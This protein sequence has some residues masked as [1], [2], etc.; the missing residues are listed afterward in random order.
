MQANVTPL[1]QYGP[2]GEQWW[3][4]PAGATLYAS[5]GVPVGTA[6]AIGT[7]YLHAGSSMMADGDV[8]LPLQTIGGYDAAANVV[9]LTVTADAVRT[10]FGGA[11]AND[12]HSLQAA[13][14][15]TL[16]LPTAQPPMPVRELNIVLREQEVV[17]TIL[18]NVVKD[19]VVRRVPQGST[20]TMTETVRKE[21]AHVEVKRDEP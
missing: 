7:A 5:D 17:I 3:Q 12:F 9:H 8:Y 4:I 16:P 21:F 2:G 11:P 1:V 6:I 18:P 13:H 15:S 19:V 14:G 10:M 20:V